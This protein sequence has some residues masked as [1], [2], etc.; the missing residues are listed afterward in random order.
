MNI[1]LSERLKQLPPYLFAELENRVAEIRA[2]NVEVLDLS[3]GDPDLP[4]PSEILRVME[5]SSKDQANQGYSSSNGEPYFREA[6][7]EWYLKRFGVRLDPAR[8]ACALIGSKEGV[9]N[10]ARAFVNPGDRVMVPDPSYPVYANGGAIL[11]GGRPVKLPLLRENG[12]LPDLDSIEAEGAKMMY[13]NYPN[14]PTGAVAD[15]DFL[16]RL[17]EFSLDNNVIVCYDNAYSEMVFGPECARSILEFPGA[18]DCCIEFNSCSKTFNMTGSRIG[19]AVGSDRL[20]SGLA[21]V[22]SQIDSGPAPFI[23]R[24]AVFALSQYKDRHPPEMVSRN[25]EIYRK[26][27]DVLVKG[28]NEIGIPCEPSPATFYLWVGVTGKSLDIAMR[29]LEAG[30]VITPGIGFGEL[31]E[32]Y[33]RFSLTKEESII[34]EVISKIGA[35]G[36]SAR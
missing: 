4:T 13:L 9:A 35:A 15:D 7:A 24:A 1:E 21:K 31:G 12:F 34:R 29:L 28:L 27:M 32:G 16:R 26:R 6:V 5:E 17:I 11:T 10:I 33:I 22:K 8:E 14:N 3:I 20:I 23:Q 25:I 30:V 19:F 2:R 36:I 18:M